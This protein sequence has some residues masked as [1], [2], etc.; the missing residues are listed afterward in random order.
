MTFVAVTLKPSQSHVPVT[1]VPGCVCAEAAGAGARS[2]GQ[3]TPSVSARRVTAMARKVFI[4]F[5]PRRAAFASP[6]G[7]TVTVV[8][9]LNEQLRVGLLTSTQY[10]DVALGLTVMLL[11]PLLPG[12]GVPFW[13][14]VNWPLPT[15]PVRLDVAVAE[16]VTGPVVLQQGACRLILISSIGTVRKFDCVV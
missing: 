14:Q 4:E 15:A 5:R 2:A 8:Q 10:S 11:W 13:Y 12:M 6:Q 9:A 3:L 1:V 7:Q 16:S